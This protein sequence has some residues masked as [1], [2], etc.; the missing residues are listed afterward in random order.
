[1]RS[2][3][4]AD[5]DTRLDT[6][7]ET[8]RDAGRSRLRLAA[9]LLV[10][11]FTAGVGYDVMKTQPAYLESAT[12]VFAWPRTNTSAYA[13]TKFV[14]SSTTTG[15]AMSQV[16]LSPPIQ[17]EIRLAGGTARVSLALVN[18]YNQEEPDYGR[19]LA[20]LTALSPSADATHR[21][22]VIAARQ[23]IGL[24]AARQAAAGASPRERLSARLIADT[25]PA[26]QRG[27]LKRALGGLGVLALAAGAGLWKVID[28]RR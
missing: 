26:A 18:L 9:A 20:T 14:T 5:L 13:Y 23:L 6:R 3:L 16:L 8:E 17:R 10:A 12:I 11:L 21:T 15:E 2:F 7:L 28:A 4:G 25:G 24:L 1:M 22:F 19:P 27:S